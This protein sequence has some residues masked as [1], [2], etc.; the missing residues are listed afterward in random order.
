[1]NF[2]RR[3]AKQALNAETKKMEPYTNLERTL[4]EV[5]EKEV[6]IIVE[7]K[8]NAEETLRALFQTVFEGRYRGIAGERLE[9]KE[10]IVYFNTPRLIGYF[11][12]A[13][14]RGDHREQTLAE[15]RA[16]AYRDYGKC[17]CD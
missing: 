10:R 1:M 4:A 16:I 5:L 12:I 17:P 11:D 7:N 8:D 2:I 15:A 9:G 13:R 3:K 14:V 6:K